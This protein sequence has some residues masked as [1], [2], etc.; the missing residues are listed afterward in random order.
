METQNAI[1]ANFYA[2]IQQEYKIMAE[3]KM[4][5]SESIQ[6]VYVIPS[7]ENSLVWFGVIF[8]RSG[9][10]L[11]G[12]FRFTI[13]LAKNFPDEME[14]PIVTFQSHILHPLIDASTGRLQTKEAF[15][16]W[17]S[18]DNHVWQILKFILFIFEYS[19]V[20][21]SGDIVNK[22][23][24]DLMSQNKSEF[25]KR[26]KECVRISRDRIYDPPTVEDKH[27]ITFDQF[28]N[29]VHGSTLESIKNR[30]YATSSPPNS[31]LS[32]Y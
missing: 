21:F 13:T 7:F 4:I 1:D 29:D 15:P 20:C 31:S 2:T 18:N 27:Y 23:A 30:K 3:Y 12:I 26:V 19:H 6:G 5:Q 10:Y 9:T 8:V 32:W 16:T 17:N 25:T 28:D 22:E 11:D 24:V 14:T